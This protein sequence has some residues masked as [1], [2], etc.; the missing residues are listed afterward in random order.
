M[1]ARHSSSVQSHQRTV[2][3]TRQFAATRELLFKAWTDP[4]HLAQWWGPKG[5]TIPTCE[6]D[7]RPGGTL[8]LCMRAPD[9]QDYWMRGTY[10]EV[11]PPERLRLA[12]EADDETGKPALDGFLTVTFAERDGNATMTLQATAGGTTA[13]AGAML[14]GMQEGWDQSI[15]RLEAHVAKAARATKGKR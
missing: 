9:G 8:R 12:V 1:A 7:L 4:K 3:I 10:R 15:A 2:A 6:V 14:E 11:V 5:F 13:K